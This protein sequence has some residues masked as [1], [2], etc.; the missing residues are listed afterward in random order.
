[1]TEIGKPL[2]IQALQ[3]KKTQRVPVWFMRQ[4]GRYL[5]EYNEIRKEKGFL[6]LTQN[7][8]LAFEITMQ[9]YHRFQND[10]I[11]MFADILTPVHGAGIPLHFEEKKGPVL[12]KIV[13][14]ENDI[15]LLNENYDPLKDNGYVRELLQRLRSSIDSLDTEDKPGLLGF[16]GA[17]FT[18]AS[19]LVEGGTSKKFEKTKEILFKKPDLFHK[20]SER[21]VKISIEYLRMQLQSGAD[22]VQIFDSWGGI[23]SAEHYAEFSAPYI[24]QIADAVK[25]EFGKEKPV[26]A[27]T[28]N[29]AHLLKELN[30]LDTMAVSL[31]WRVL[32]EDVDRLIDET[33]AIQGNMDPM[34]LYGTPE[35]TRE[36]TKKVLDRFGSR[37]GGYVFNL[38]HGIHPGASIECVQVMMD[39]V[40]EYRR[41]V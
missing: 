5:P 32:P 22:A 6:E 2:I 37:N 7:P 13:E 31:D 9:P 4:A 27:F 11:I 18:L 1:M 38:G 33:K 35:R 15:D 3:G 17:P 10:G 14:S 30:D 25:K 19:Y 26:I 24:K 28:G 36:E 23:L 34:I 16:A 12:E 29:S 41:T 20:L 39:T 8:D 40:R 21:L